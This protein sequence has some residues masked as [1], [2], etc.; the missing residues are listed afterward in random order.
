[1]PTTQR[2]FRVDVE[3]DGV[4]DL[5][6][7]EQ[8]A[9]EF[10]R[11]APGELVAAAVK[12]LTVELFDAVIGPFGFP[13]ADG[14]Q[15]EA[16]WCC[17]GCGSR[18]GFRR[19]GQR[20]GG[21]TVTTAAGRVRMEAWQVVCR[22]CGRRFVPVLELLGL[23]AHQRRSVALGELAAGLAVEV[24]YAKASRLLSELA[25]I[26]VSARTIRRDT[27]AVA[28][29]RLGPEDTS[30]PVLLLDGTGVRAGDKKLGVELHLAVG[31]V[32]RRREGGR[33]VVEARLLGATVGEAWSAMAALLEGVRPGLVI[34][35][36]EEAI[37]DLAETLF[38]TAPIQRCLFHLESQTR[39]MAR[40]L[41][42]MAPAV[43]DDLRER[44]HGLLADAYATG[45]LGA[46]VDA[47]NDLI[48]HARA[49]GADKA[50]G[51]LVNAAPHALTFLTHPEA[52]RLL[53]GDKG[54]PELAT[55][56]L[57]RV[58]REMNRRTDVGVRWS[59][60][61]VRGMLMVKLGRKY[62]HGR[63]AR[64]ELDPVDTP[65]PARFALAA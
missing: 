64:P 7:L 41:D 12:A 54:R 61:G 47:Y 57:E 23:R 2:S 42:R 28:P 32:A 9:L 59:V 18:R 33:V 15:P 20:P 49:V 4:V 43:A 5:D 31:L 21:R 8:A 17:T 58:M 13:L 16:P 62:S 55:G 56:V 25:G 35:D 3:M 36:G 60:P 46:A 44:V 40:Y 38:P 53:F 39:W 34:V 37:T 22:G 29:E 63:W 45:D 11:R 52:G 14:D 27:L 50:A 65:A 30:V 19:R 6:Q 10:A 26:D 51:H 24:A 48:G 1:M